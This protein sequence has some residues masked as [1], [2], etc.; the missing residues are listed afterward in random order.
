MNIRKKLTFQFTLI[1]LLI[2]ISFSAAI[3]FASASF[4]RND[5]TNRLE[6]RANT[7]A[8]L[9]F[10]FQHLDIELLEIINRNTISL[11]DESI[12]IFD[13][14]YQE[15]YSSNI[16][17]TLPFPVEVFDQVKSRGRY[18]ELSG[19]KD[20]I[21]IPYADGSDTY[22]I[23]ASANDIF[24]FRKL[25]NLRLILLI[26]LSVSFVLTILSGM[27][28]AGRAI[29]PIAIITNQ[30]K[31]I[32]ASSLNMRLEKRKG[33][34]EIADLVATFNNMLERIE[35]GFELQKTFISNASHEFR[36]PFTSI[37]AKYDMILMQNRSEQEYREI[38]Q[39][40]YADLRK[41]NTLSEEML[42]LAYANLDTSS[43]QFSSLRIDEVLFNTH[44][45][46]KQRWPE[47]HVHFNFQSLPEDES[48][49]TVTGSEQLLKTAFINLMNNGCKFSS[50]KTIVVKL[51]HINS[52]LTVEFSDNGIGIPHNERDAIF[53]PFY[54]AGNVTGRQG[55]GLGLSIVK[56]IVEHHQGNIHVESEVNAGSR[57]IVELPVA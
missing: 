24:G 52:K 15:I 11:I 36:T 14:N 29:R 54:R 46:F 32:T 22:Y 18:N 48:F 37:F 44:K 45:E 10:T 30:V 39:S 34:D 16:I 28:Y 40:V 7:T 33:K 42:D 19:E 56:K 35:A 23:L 53:E 51:S 3:Y 5:F 12:R 27:F 38:I 2:L 25:Q 21:G 4:R 9:L 13:S 55:H 31:M 8:K 1:V 17:D 49:L 57:F 6:D 50:D 43:F 20:F 26:G 41:L 47:F